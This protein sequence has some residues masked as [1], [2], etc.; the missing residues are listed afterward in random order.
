MTWPSPLCCSL[1]SSWR[2][3]I[4][5]GGHQRLVCRHVADS[6]EAYAAF[7]S[8]MLRETVFAS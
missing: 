8:R 7:V 5:D 3:R 1:P 4:R 6:P 2:R